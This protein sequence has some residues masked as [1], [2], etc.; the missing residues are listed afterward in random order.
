F[1]YINEHAVRV[2]SWRHDRETGGVHFVIIARGD[3]ERDLLLD[4]FARQ[5]VM[6]RTGSESAIPMDVHSLE[7][8]TTESG[9][10]SF[11][12]LQVTLA[13][14]GA[15]RPRKERQQEAP[16]SRDKL[17][18]VIELL[19]EIRD[20]LREIRRDVTGDRKSTRLNSS[21]VKISYAVFCLKKQ[22]SR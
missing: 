9:P 2:T 5:P 16:P 15:P 4:S 18:R 10:R 1:V 3:H 20:E 21:H 8:T 14:E 11:H 17:D 13:P 6:I 22:N 19:T 12:R 7:T